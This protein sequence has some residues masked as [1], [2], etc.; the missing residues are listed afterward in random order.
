VNKQLI[1]V[2]ITVDTAKMKEW[3]E[4]ELKKNSQA[5]DGYYE[6]LLI[7]DGQ[8]VDMTFEEFKERLTKA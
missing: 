6:V 2:H 5:Y 1:G 7:I 4:G 8:A 3:M